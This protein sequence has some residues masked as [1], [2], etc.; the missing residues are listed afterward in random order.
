MRIFS[1]KIVQKLNFEQKI[2]LKF[3]YGSTKTTVATRVPGNII[4]VLVSTLVPGTIP[5]YQVSSR[6]LVVTFKTQR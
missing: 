6:A 2:D 5:Q 3:S 1:N 4:P